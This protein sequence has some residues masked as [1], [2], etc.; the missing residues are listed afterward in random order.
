MQHPHFYVDMAKAIRHILAQLIP[1]L[2]S[3]FLRKPPAEREEQYWRLHDQCEEMQ[4]Q[5]GTLF[6]WMR[7]LEVLGF[8][9]TELMEYGTVTS[10]EQIDEAYTY[11]WE[12]SAVPQHGSVAEQPQ[13]TE[14]VAEQ[15]QLQAIADQP[16]SQPEQPAAVKAPC[17]VWQEDEEVVLL[18]IWG[19]YESQA[20][21]KDKTNKPMEAKQ[22]KQIWQL[23][24]D[25]LYERQPQL[26]GAFAGTLKQKVGLL[27]KGNEKLVEK[28]GTSGHGAAFDTPV[29]RLREQISS[30]DPLVNPTY[31]WTVTQPPKPPRSV[32]L[33]RQRPALQLAQITQTYETLYRNADH[34]IQFGVLQISH[35]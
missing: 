4:A 25:K 33:C 6:K 12:R 30:K 35:S 19:E 5:H 20:F 29:F 7:D 9:D 26:R 11:F 27:V 17:R 15:L 18:S 14:T 8:A 21:R 1:L 28:H 31:F 22:V 3:E 10:L 34:S 23:T 13:S 24:E 2:T 32:S 16:Q